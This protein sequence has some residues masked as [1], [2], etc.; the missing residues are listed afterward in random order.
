MNEKDKNFSIRESIYNEKLK[1]GIYDENMKDLN[2]DELKEKL[3]YLENEN[4]R[5]MEINSIIKNIKQQIN[6]KQNKL[7]NLKIDD[8]LEDLEKEKINIY[9]IINENKDNIKNFN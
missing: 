6:D 5:Y 2:I 4:C 8:N 7:N 3:K 1:K 9:S